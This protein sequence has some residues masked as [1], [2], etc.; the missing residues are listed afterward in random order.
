M[1][2]PSVPRL[3]DLNRIWQLSYRQILEGQPPR[4]VLSKV[5]LLLE[6]CMGAMVSQ[7]LCHHG[8]A[9]WK[10]LTTEATGGCGELLNYLNYPIATEASILVRLEAC[11][12]VMLMLLS[13]AAMVMV[14]FGG[15]ISHLTA[16]MLDQFDELCSCVIHILVH[17]Q[18]MYL[19]SCVLKL[20]EHSR[21][22]PHSSPK[23]QST[24]AILNDHGSN[25][26]ERHSQTCYNYIVSKYDYIHPCLNF[27][28]HMS[29]PVHGACGRGV[30]EKRLK[31]EWTIW[32]MYCHSNFISCFTHVV[33]FLIGAIKLQCFWQGF[34]PSVLHLV[35][36]FGSYHA[37]LSFARA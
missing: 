31:H 24:E 22:S 35:F 10:I 25:P 33:W 4:V 1:T 36:D 2:A 17:G 23:K 34:G 5:L 18:D 7:F 6:V 26:T 16:R 15:F 14:L 19:K 3:T 27:K 9:P 21:K 11:H 28:N 37:G 13:L 30:V 32:L 20:H 8:V 12:E 29:T